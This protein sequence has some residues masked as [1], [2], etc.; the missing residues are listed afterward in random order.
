MKFPAQ[1]RMKGDITAFKPKIASLS[2]LK[3]PG[4]ATTE[5]IKHL[6]DCQDR[7]E[8]AK[9]RLKAL[10]SDA[11]KQR[12]RRAVTDVNDVQR[13]KRRA[14]KKKLVSE[15]AS[16][17]TANASKVRKFIHST[18]GRPPLEEAYLDLHKTTVDLATA[19]A[20]ADS[21]RHN[22]VLDAC[23]ALDNLR[24]V[25]LK[26]GHVLTRT[27]LCL[28]LISRRSDPV[29]GKQLVRTVPVKIRKVKNN[30]RNKH[31]DTKF[32]FATKQYMKDIASLL[33]PENMF[34]LSV[35]GKA[36]VSIDVTTAT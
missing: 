6:N 27:A 7:L 3:E 32:T 12:K 30:L 17:S 20:G 16:L 11:E 31:Q 2:S 24:A 35:D 23:E 18:S 29:E 33:G 25:L 15:L 4:F 36:K 10:V 26:E 28:C 5:N 19:R 34:A 22:D 13:K 1:D 14:V 8:Q 9:Q 21:R